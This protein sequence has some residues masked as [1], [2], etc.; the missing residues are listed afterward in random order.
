VI[1]EECVT[2]SGDDHTPFEQI[3]R[4]VADILNRLPEQRLRAAIILGVSFLDEE[5]SVMLKSRM[6]HN[7]ERNDALFDPDRPLGSLSA[8][9]ELAYRLYHIDADFKS[10]LDTLRRL[11]N[12]CAHSLDDIVI[13][14]PPHRDRINAVG[15]SMRSNPYWSKMYPFFLEDSGVE[16]LAV[17]LAS[18]ATLIFSYEI[19]KNEDAQEPVSFHWKIQD[20]PTKH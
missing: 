6:H 16:E 12:D 17:F 15:N 2:S 9:I 4:R 18:M 20:T 8:R 14:K 11:R 5:L 7:P 1:L 3:A 19:A 10:C 13:F